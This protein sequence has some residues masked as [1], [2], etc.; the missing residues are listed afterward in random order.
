MDSPSATTLTLATRSLIAALALSVWSPARPL[1]VVTVKP[2]PNA[3]SAPRGT[4]IVMTFDEDVDPATVNSRSLR[5]FGRWSGVIRGVRRVVNGTTVLFRPLRPFMPGEEVRVHVSSSVAST[6]GS[7]LV[8]GRAWTFWAR[9]PLGTGAFEIAGETTTRLP[10]EGMVQSYGIYAG[11]LDHDGAPDFTVPNEIASDVRVLMNDGCGVFDGPTVHPLAPGA[12]PSANEGADFDGDGHVDYAT[13]DIGTGTVSVL[14]GDGTGGFAPPVAYPSGVVARSVVP[15]DAEGDGDVDLV[16]AHRG[17]SD[18]GLHLNAGDGTFAP[19]V[20]FEGGGDGETSVAAADADND[21]ITDLYVACHGS[22]SVTS[23]RGTGGAF[24]VVDSEPVGLRPW[25]IVS[26]DV[27]GDGFSDLAVSN[28]SSASASI[29]LG[30]GAGGLLP[31][32]HVS[33]GAFPTA[34][35]LGDLDGDGDLDLVGSAVSGGHWAVWR[36]DGTGTFVDPTLLP[37]PL[38]ASCATLVDFDRDGYVDIVGLDEVTDV[39]R[40]WRQ[41]PVPAPGVEEPGC[42]AT[43]RLDNAATQSGYG[44][45]AP[46]AVGLGD[47][48]YLGFTG[49]PGRLYLLAFGAGLE[50]GAPSSYGLLNLAAPISA[51][52]IGVLDDRGESTMGLALPTNLVPGATVSLQLFVQAVGGVV[53][54]NPETILVTP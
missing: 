53:L 44:L 31:A 48:V 49:T 39:V 13:A 40:F 50:P 38:A 21:G 8:N 36:N 45:Q 37:A 22:D 9:A 43:L 26:G 1:D 33:I 6:S 28:S 24:T 42:T 35:D 32:T 18:L 47:Y 19:V 34:V 3:T 17:S 5:V 10:G 54:S 15:L 20:T 4:S 12:T 14:M 41:I 30:D 51:P 23:L 25:V 16:A 2:T 27:D 29:V 46:H 11:D 7:P 52:L